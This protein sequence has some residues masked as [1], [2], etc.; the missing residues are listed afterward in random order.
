[1][2]DVEDAWCQPTWAWAR[3]VTPALLV[4]H[5]DSGFRGQNPERREIVVDAKGRTLYRFTTD[6]D[7]PMTT[8][9]TGA[10]LEMWKPAALVAKNDV[11]GIGPKLVIPDSISS[12]G[13]C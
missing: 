1:M 5:N 13:A 3:W 11:K 4:S 12:I 10:C 9:C 8:A 7:W 2:V 6:T